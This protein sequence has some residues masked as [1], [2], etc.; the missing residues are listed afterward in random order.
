MNGCG[1]TRISSLIRSDSSSVSAVVSTVCTLYHT[2]RLDL[3]VDDLIRDCMHALAQRVSLAYTAVY[4]IPKDQK[5]LMELM[6][7]NL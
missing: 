1:Q 5:Q 4:Q 2:G 3:I 6:L 7:H